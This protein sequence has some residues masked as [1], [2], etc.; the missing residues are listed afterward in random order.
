MATS[1]GPNRG[2]ERASTGEAQHRRARCNLKPSKAH[3]WY[4]RVSF[5]RAIAGMAA[6]VAL[7]SA[8]VAL[9]I[10]SELSSRSTLFQHRMELMRSRISSLRTRVADAEQ[11][12]AAMNADVLARREV[13]R[14][15]SAS[16]VMLLRLTPGADNS[17][18]GLIAISQKAG[19]AILEIEGLSTVL[20]KTYVMWWLPAQGLA[21]S[22]AVFNPGPDGRRSIAIRMPP[23]AAPIT[24]AIVTL[25]PS[26]APA[27]PRGKIILRGVLPRPRILS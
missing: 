4:H 24:A 26:N 9:E 3:P 12:V 16:D 2:A 27:Q 11:Q 20:G 8:V 1:E 17:A 19:N 18:R 21:A 5:W 15:L 25:E 10:A 6:A 7:G 13:N 23:R 22:G 14:V